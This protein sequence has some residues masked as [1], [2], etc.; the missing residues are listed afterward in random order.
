MPL[1]A[2]SRLT[3]LA[4]ACLLVAAGQADP[5]APVPRPGPAPLADSAR[6]RGT[7]G[8][9][10]IE[11]SSGGGIVPW[12]T[13]AGYGSEDAV[14]G[15]AH[16]TVIRLSDFKLASAG[17]NIGLFNRI[18]VS[19]ARQ[20]LDTGRTG[21]GLGLGR[22]LTLR[23]DTVGLKVRVLGDVVYGPVL[24]PQIAVGVQFKQNARRSIV[25]A[26]GAR[27]ATGVDV[28]AAATKL[29]LNH[30]VL[31]NATV[32][33]T[34]ANQAGLLGFGGPESNGYRP[35]FEASI[36]WLPSRNL[37]IGAEVRTQPSMLHST[38]S[39]PWVDAF[40]AWFPTKNVS[41]TLAYLQFGTV[42]TRDHQSGVQISAQMG[43]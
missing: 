5:D 12:A 7:A 15:T 10:A 31:V 17:A 18:E 25:T 33:L 36:A 37:A 22:G 24:V 14:G 8:V 16:V 41:A 39:S 3:V 4:A 34:R 28:Y 35:V 23:L 32:R 20:V 1:C 6:L 43:F 38:R 26:L 30:S 27:G 21:Q 9:A 19:Y 13:I 42:G 2:L 11:G 29:L 40:I